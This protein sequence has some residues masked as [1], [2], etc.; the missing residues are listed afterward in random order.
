MKRVLLTLTLTLL[1]LTTIYAEAPMPIATYTFTTTDD[2][3]T[4]NITET[5][6]G[7]EFQEF[8]GKA[9]LLAL[10][11]HRCPPCIREIPEFIELTKKHKNDLEIVAIESQNSPVD[12][13]IA[14]K[15]EYKMN[16]N[17]IAGVNYNDFITRIAGRA[18][19]PK[20]KIP[21]PLLIAIDKE[22]EVQYVQA[23]QLSQN[24]L[25]SLVKELNE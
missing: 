20:G 6:E 10:F 14:L 11:G 2:N 5:Q 22:G 15:K 21:L 25:E 17:V 1:S 13:V 24:E 8:K 16:Y 23:G 3:K 4:L 18:G 12:E 19:Y 9:V 7:L